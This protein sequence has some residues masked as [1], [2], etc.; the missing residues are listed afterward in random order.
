MGRIVTAMEEV[1]KRHET[2]SAFRGESGVGFAKR[3]GRFTLGEGNRAAP[4]RPRGTSAALSGRRY[5]TVNW[6]FT[7]RTDS[8]FPT[9]C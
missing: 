1:L 3:A 8:T 5:F 2:S 7:F 9:I 4:I 6:E